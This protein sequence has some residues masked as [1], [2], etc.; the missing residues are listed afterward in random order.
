MSKRLSELYGMDMYTQ[1]AQYIGKVED[2]ILNIEQGEIMRL[3]MKNFRGS[4]LPSDE[5]RKIL[6]EDSVAYDEVLE[7]GDIILVEKMPVISKAK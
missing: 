1:K 5:V 4:K 2:V 7:V 3:C 6:T